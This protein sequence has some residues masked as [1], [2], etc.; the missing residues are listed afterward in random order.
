MISSTILL[1]ILLMEF[2]RSDIDIG[3][4]DD[5]DDDDGDDDDGDDD[6][7]VDVSDCWIRFLSAA[8]N[9]KDKPSLII[10]MTWFFKPVSISISVSVSWNDNIDDL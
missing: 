7:N 6:G 9:Q 4:D 2:D 3:D 8:L 1:A 5:D 10:I